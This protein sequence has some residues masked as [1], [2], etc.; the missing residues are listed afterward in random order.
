MSQ[1]L[2]GTQPIPAIITNA[3]VYREGADLIGAG[4]V[5]LPQ[6]EMM[7]ETLSGFAIAGEVD[8]PVTGHFGG[9]ELTIK[10]NA[11]CPEALSLL[12]NRAHHLDIRASLQGYDSSTGMMKDIPIKVVAR[13]L[14]KSVSLGTFEPAKKAEAESKLSL[15]YVKVWIGGVERVEI[16]KLNFICTVGGNDLLATVRAN[17]GI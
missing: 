16:D 7:S 10:W 5:E 1:M 9:M 12:E 2:S 4:S 3:R 6:L 14:P 11:P 15:T 8:M 13:G 17:L